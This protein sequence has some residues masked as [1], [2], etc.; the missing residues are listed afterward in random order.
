MAETRGLVWQG[1][2]LKSAEISGLASSRLPAERNFKEL[3]AR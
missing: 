1:M 3:A 2:A